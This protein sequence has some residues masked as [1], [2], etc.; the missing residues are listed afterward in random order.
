MLKIDCARWNQNAAILREE[1]LKAA[2]ARSRER[3]MALYEICNGKNATQVGKET[4]RNPQTIMEWV[5]RYNLSGMEALRYQHTGGHP[6][7][8]LQR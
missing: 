2:H 5:H 4:G 1:A 6:P 8:F 3:F 7:F